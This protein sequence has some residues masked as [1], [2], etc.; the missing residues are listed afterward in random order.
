MIEND[1]EE[2]FWDHLKDKIFLGVGF[3]IE[4]VRKE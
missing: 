1:A 2:L 3:Y 4:K